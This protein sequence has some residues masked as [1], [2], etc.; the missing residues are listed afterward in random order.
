MVSEAQKRGRLFPLL[1]YHLL[2]TSA[3]PFWT[4]FFPERK[5]SLE[6]L[7]FEASQIGSGV[8]AKA[9]LLAARLLT[10]VQWRSQL[11]PPTGIARLQ[12]S[13]LQVLAFAGQHSYQPDPA[14]HPHP[15]NSPTS[16]AGSTLVCTSDA[17]TML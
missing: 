3:L 2:S 9:Q 6:Q 1:L 10:R 15:W 7:S 11:A 8:F 5:R 13:G 17:K 14:A 16:A 12:I 4:I